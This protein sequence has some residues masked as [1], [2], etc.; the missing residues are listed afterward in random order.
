M[1]GKQLDPD[2]TKRY[3]SNAIL[4]CLHRTIAIPEWEKLRTGEDVSLE[5]ALGA[6]DMFVLETGPGDFDDVRKIL[7]PRLGTFFYT[8]DNFL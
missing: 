1:Y 2:K 3:Y 5:R 8:D 4:T 6:F 7:I